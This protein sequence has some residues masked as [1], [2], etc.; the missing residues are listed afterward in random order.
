MNRP[1]PSYGRPE[2]F[3]T[4]QGGQF[5][6]DE[7]TTTLK[8]HEIA[9]SMVGRHVMNNVAEIFNLIERLRKETIGEPSWI[10]EKQVFEYQ[11][12]T[13]TVVAVL[14]LI[15]AAHGVTALDLLCRAGLFIDFGAIMRCVGDCKAEVVF[16]LEHFPKTSSN[17]DKFVK[18]FFQSTIDGYLTNDLPSVPTQKIRSAMVRVLKGH[19][20]EPTSVLFDDI[21]KTFCGYIHANYANIMEVYG[22]K[23]RSFN[24]GGVPCFQQRQERLQ[25]VE[26]A[27]ESVLQTAAFIART[28]GL[29]DLYDENCPTA[30]IRLGARGHNLS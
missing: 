5:T 6:S 19:Q 12:H 18:A 29:Q 21:Y 26:L 8:R 15:R 22:G 24:L 11:D 2:I 28:L 16:L 23:P 9:I 17:V 14:K 25:H 27:V 30:G 7:F 13:A 20:D 4:D 3:N 10:P 1:L